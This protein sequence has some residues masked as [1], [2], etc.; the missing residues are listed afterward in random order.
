LS[1]VSVALLT[2]LALADS[3]SSLLPTADGNYTQWTTVGSGS[4]FANIDETPCNGTTDYNRTTTVG[5]RD[6]YV[7]TDGVPN[8]ARITQ[9][10]IKPCAS[11]DSNGGTNP[12]MNVFYRFGGINSA[13]AGAYSLTG[14][15]PAEI[16]T[17]TFSGLSLLKTATTTLEVG[18]VLTSSTKGARLSKIATVVTYNPLIDPSGATAAASTSEAGVLLQWTDNSSIETNFEVVRST[19]GSNFSHLA[20]TSANVIS[21]QDT[22]V[23]AS[24]VYYYKVRAHNFGGYSAFTNTA[25]TTTGSIP[26]SPSDLSASASTT[27]LQINL[28]WTDTSD[29]EKNFVLERGLSTSTFSFLKTVNAGVTSTTDTSLSANT[30]YYYRVSASNGYGTSSPSASASATAASIPADPSG[31]TLSTQPAASSTTDIIL[32]WAD[33][34]SNELGFKIE[35]DSGS[36]FSQIAT[37]TANAVTYTDASRP[38]G[39]YAYRLRAFNGVGSS[40]YTNTATTAVPI[41]WTTHSTDLEQDNEQY[42][43]IDDNSSLSFNGSLTMA[44]W[45]KMESLPTAVMSTIMRKWVDC[46]PND[47]GYALDVVFNS[48]SGT[49]ELHIGVVG[50]GGGD[51]DRFYAHY[52]FATSTWYHVAGTLNNSS[53]EYTLY[54]NGTPLSNVRNLAG[55]AT[56][57]GTQG[58]SGDNPHPLVF[59]QRKWVSNAVCSGPAGADYLDGKIDDIRLWNRELSSGDISSLY[60]NPG[61]F[62]N[63]TDMKGWWKFDNDATDSSGEG[64]NLTGVNGPTFTTDTP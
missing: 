16:A 13:D 17:T 60:S 27:A 7:V 12:V 53:K 58:L 15:T 52:P 24:T 30:T 9:I 44:A 62:S 29:N 46:D 64:N 19:D 2:N 14:T 3:T 40:G 34:S 43:S 35:R 61:E 20:T 21:Y 57:T 47:G 10:E 50:S 55:V 51:G 33:N 38:D 26:S 23:V 39:T 56:S 32:D 48:V 31:L 59:G 11:R 8:G 63:G 42:W 49:H 41:I 4:H 54:V 25:T 28:N 1:I 18:A 37:T 5:N 22:N 45:V 36:G 6:S